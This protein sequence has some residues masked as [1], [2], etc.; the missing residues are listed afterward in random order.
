MIVFGYVK[1]GEILDVIKKRMHNHVLRAEEL[2][3]KFDNETND[4]L[5][6][7]YWAELRDI[8]S[9]VLEDAELQETILSKRRSF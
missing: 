7:E 6:R 8:G 4:E 3:S 5:R 1:I 9:R 2:K